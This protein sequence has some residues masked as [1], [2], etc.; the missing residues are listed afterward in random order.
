[1]RAMKW[2]YLPRRIAMSLSWTT[3]SEVGEVAMMSAA[4]E[5]R[6]WASTVAGIDAVSPAEAVSNEQY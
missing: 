6:S 5:V 4:A 1:M 2:K 3:S